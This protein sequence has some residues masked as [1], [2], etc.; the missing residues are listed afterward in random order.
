M[1][2]RQC[3]AD[4]CKFNYCLIGVQYQTSTERQLLDFDGG[5]ASNKKASGSCSQASPNVFTPL[6]LSK[7]GEKSKERLYFCCK[8][9]GTE[10]LKLL[11]IGKS[12][13]SH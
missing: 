13:E 9:S 1:C 3:L 12:L 10:K 2:I 8:A 6:D 5:L 7:G 11:L 4:C